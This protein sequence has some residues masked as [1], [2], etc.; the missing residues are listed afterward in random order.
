MT[1]VSTLGME[2]G[3]R[4]YS[5]VAVK[6]WWLILSASFDMGRLSSRNSFK[7]ASLRSSQ[8]CSG[9]FSARDLEAIVTARRLSNRSKNE[10]GNGESLWLTKEQGKGQVKILGDEHN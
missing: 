8:S 3:R 9:I 4:M 1:H 7:I 10:W 5:Y 2:I 6:P